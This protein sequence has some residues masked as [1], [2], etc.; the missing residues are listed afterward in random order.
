LCL[1]ASPGTVQDAEA[2]CWKEPPKGSSLALLWP[3]LASMR[4]PVPAAPG[5]AIERASDAPPLA[6]VPLAFAL[7]P[8]APSLPLGANRR[9][10]DDDGRPPFDWAAESARRIGIVAH[11]WL[12]RIAEHGLD[13]WPSSAVDPLA[14]RVDAEL[15]DHGFTDDERPAAVGKVLEAVRRTLADPRGRWL[16]DPS[17][18]EAHSE[19]P[20]AGI[21]GGA[22]AH[23]VVDRTFV[24]DGERWIVD[25]KTG[26]HEGG[27]AAAFLESEAIRYRDQLARYGRLLHALDGRPVRL[28]LYYPLVRDGFVE[29]GDRQ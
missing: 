4:P 17:H 12:A 22:V 25:F 26:T 2:T 10:V 1:V 24:V 16:F 3:A 8:P 13:A 19:W 23:V 9:S 18:A 29:V 20:I 5:D 11:R 27:D 21:D 15:A 28:A 6:R 7:P 14:A